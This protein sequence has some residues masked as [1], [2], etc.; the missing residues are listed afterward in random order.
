MGWVDVLK[1]Q[2]VGLDSAPI[3]YFT[4]ENSAY[5]DI[6]DPFFEAIGSGEIAAVTSMITVTE[7]LVHPVQNEDS[8][9]IQKYRTLLF[10]TRGLVTISLSQKIA[11]EA[12]RL[13]ALHNFRTPDSIQIATAIIA[14]AS[15][16]LTNDKQLRSL[17]DLKILLL[18]DLKKV[19]QGTN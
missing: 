18:D 17:P 10:K 4:E 5:Q 1:G 12:A 19:Q 2:V 7:V 13:R 16:F 14:K 11:E 9:L 15:F 8:E 3:I 6:V